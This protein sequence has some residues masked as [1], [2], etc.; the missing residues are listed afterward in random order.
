MNEDPHYHRFAATH[1]WYAII[2]DVTA[3]VTRCS[4]RD[5]QLSSNSTGMAP[6]MASFDNDHT[7]T[8]VCYFLHDIAIS[9]FFFN[10]DTSL[11]SMRRRRTKDTTNDDEIFNARDTN[12]S[13]HTHIYYF[14][15]D[16]KLF[17]RCS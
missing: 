12:K 10:S 5:V 11:R 13:V 3:D 9:F 7:P 8:F 2:H 14:L 4:S 17:E 6:G 1:T 16:D 15:K